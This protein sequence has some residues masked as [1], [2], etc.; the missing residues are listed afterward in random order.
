VL[1][2]LLSLSQFYARKSVLFFYDENLITSTMAET[3]RYDSNTAL[4]GRGKIT[5]AKLAAILRK[6]L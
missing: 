3:C 4:E 5:C 2:K 6:R 1:I